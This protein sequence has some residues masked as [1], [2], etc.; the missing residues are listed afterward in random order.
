MWFRTPMP[1][2]VIASHS[3]YMIQR[4]DGI[5][6]LFKEG[7]DQVNLFTGAVPAAQAAMSALAASVGAYN[8]DA[9]GPNG[10][11]NWFMFNPV[12]FP[13]QTRLLYL[14]AFS[15]FER[16]PDPLNT[17]RIVAS[18]GLTLSVNMTDAQATAMMDKLKMC[19]GAIT[20]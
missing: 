10:V 18:Y 13:N 3:P 19:V 17:F 2:D 12:S 5:I 16:V 4:A 8:F 20:L 9:G 11:Y 1:T 15:R 14:P 6:D 7:A